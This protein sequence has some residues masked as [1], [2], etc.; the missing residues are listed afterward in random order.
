MLSEVVKQTN[1][2]K[3]D[4]VIKNL[5][6]RGI[7]AQKADSA[8]EALALALKF[9]KPGD[10]V[11]FGGS[12]SVNEIGLKEEVDKL[13]VRVFDHGR[14]KS[15]EEAEAAR[16][17]ALGSDV[18]F[19]SSNAVTIDGVLMNIDGTGN[20]VA[21]L[22]YGPKQV[23]IIIGANKITADEDSA[24]KR[25]KTDACSANAVRLGRK[26]PCAL[27]GKCGDCMNPDATL[28]SMI[29]TTR[30]CYTNRLN[31]IMVNENLGF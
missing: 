6:K 24:L 19:M 27:T 22:C 25:I 17:G 13:D 30:F 20:R 1:D 5:E 29:L 4:T 23:V 21:A 28:C 26:T 8:A 15:P 9:V 16:T 3:I 18:Y 11:A 7:K 14:A 10:V 12:A 31:V 2:V